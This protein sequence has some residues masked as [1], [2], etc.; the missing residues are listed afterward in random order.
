MLHLARLFLVLSV[1]ALSLLSS[2]GEKVS[3]KSNTVAKVG[4]QVLTS[5]DVEILSVIENWFSY[6]NSKGSGKKEKLGE[7]TDWFVTPS[8]PAYTKQ[9]NALVAEHL[10][11]LEDEN[12]SVAKVSLAD[13]QKTTKSLLD[14]VKTW[15]R[16]ALLEVSESE[17][18]RNI[19]RH[20]RTKQFLKLKMESM[21]M[22][23]S[24]EE[25]R[26]YFEQNKKDFNNLP[27]ETFRESIKEILANRDVQTKMKGWFDVLRKK[28]KAKLLKFK[29]E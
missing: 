6:S 25:A 29:S 13:V 22:L 16:W 7:Q 17:L 19:Q 9:L 14:D 15:E 24:D 23:V 28:Y 26:E 5:R 11:L 21:G 4:D 10:I 27:F 2:A 3:R 8:S 1:G 20:L 18:E 12:F